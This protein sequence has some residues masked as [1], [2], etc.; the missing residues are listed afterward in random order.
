MINLDNKVALVTGS[1]DGIGAAATSLFSS[2]GAKVTKVRRNQSKLDKVAAECQSK[3]P[4]HY[5][6]LVIKADFT[7]DEDVVRAFNE[8]ISA[9]NRLDILV[10]NAGIAANKEFGDPGYLEDYDQIMH[11]NVRAV[12]RLTELATSSLAESK[13]AIINVSSAGSLIANPNAFWAYGMSKAALDM[14]TKSMAGKLAPNIR[15]NSV[16]PGIVRTSFLRATPDP[17]AIQDYLA[18]MQPLKRVADPED[19]AQL[20]SFLA[21][22]AS[23]NMTGSIVVSDSGYLVVDPYNIKTE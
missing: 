19:I 14:F 5:K 11:V 10:N 13:G 17:T 20:I 16:N 15:V 22:D 4:H 12:V 6:P 8:T 2:L 3:S 7:R 21:S 1:S 18:K 23:R 9:Y